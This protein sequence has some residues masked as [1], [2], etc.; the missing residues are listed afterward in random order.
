MPYVKRDWMIGTELVKQGTWVPERN[1]HGWQDRAKHIPADD[2]VW[3]K[4]TP[5]TSLPP[6]FSDDSSD[7]TPAVLVVAGDMA[8]AQRD[9]FLYANMLE[10][11]KTSPNDRTADE[12]VEQMRALGLASGSWPELVG[13]PPTH[14]SPRPF[15]KM[16][17]WFLSLM[18]K[19][20]KCLL[21]C[22]NYVMTSLDNVSAVAVGVSLPPSVSFEFPASMFDS[23]EQWHTAWRFIDTMVAEFN[24]GDR[25]LVIGH[26][27]QEFPDSFARQTGVGALT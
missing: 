24:V 18:G 23:T 8:S 5:L 17:D 1:W 10:R 26:F 9:G 25:F 13:G 20:T 14:E 4:D 12:I 21:K 11:L 15:R 6:R 7:D 22:V 2:Q 19:V 16:V 3:R 27:T